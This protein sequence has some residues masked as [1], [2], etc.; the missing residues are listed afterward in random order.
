VSLFG[1]ATVVGLGTELARPMERRRFRANF[2]VDWEDARPFRENEL[3][4]RTVR[5]GDRLRIAILEGAPRCKM[6]T[7]DPDTAEGRQGHPS[8]RHCPAWLSRGRLRCGADR[9]PRAS[10]RPDLARGIAPAARKSRRSRYE[11]HDAAEFELF[12]AACCLMGTYFGL[13]DVIAH[14]MTAK[15]M[16]NK[17]ARDFLAHLFAGLSETARASPEGSFE[18]LRTAYSS[19]GGLNEQVFDLFVSHGA[20]A[21]SYGRARS[22]VLE[23]C[24]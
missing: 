23:T 17:H 15:G 16:L 19:K 8:S 18:E 6:I 21:G 13:L 7:I 20:A 10:W 4:G 1:N 9:G 14:W 22:R 24:P 11:A 12:G 3:V 5:V 2:Y